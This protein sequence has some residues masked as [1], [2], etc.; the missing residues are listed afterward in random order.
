MDG[1]ILSANQGMLNLT[2]QT[3]DALHQ[4]TMDALFPRFNQVFLQT[5]V[6]P[7]LFSEGSV[8]E[9]YLHL[10]GNKQQLVPVLVNCKK[11][12]P[13]GAERYCWIFFVAQE[14]SRFENELL[15]ARAH[16]ENMSSHLARANAELKIM[17][18]QLAERAHHLELANFE[19]A[20]LS[21]SDPLTGLGN[22]R[23]LTRAIQ[24][25]QAERVADQQLASLLIVD[26]DHFKAVNDQHGHDEGDRVLVLLA[27]QLLVSVREC[28]LA[29]R[30]GGEEFA[31]WLPSTNRDDAEHIAQRVHDHIQMIQVDGKSITVS[32]GVATVS[33]IKGPELMHRLIEQADKAVYRA[34]AAG[35]NRT[36]HYQALALTRNGSRNSGGPL[37]RMPAAW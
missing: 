21:H 18:R 35:R 28:D 26:V 10:Y 23:A 6:W 34:K 27:H 32:I 4:S 36:L 33:D 31:L 9:I 13:P 1:H 25:W 19:L 11:S 15:Q 22:R 3:A 5:H 2:G 16:S 29:V 17:H 7:M 12:G 30:Y 37:D 8:H 24:N 14:R 20:R